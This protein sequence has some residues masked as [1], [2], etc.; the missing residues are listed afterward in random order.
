[1]GLFNSQVLA[2]GDKNP[3]AKSKLEKYIKRDMK[4]PKEIQQRHLEVKSPVLGLVSDQTLGSKDFA[5]SWW[6]ISEP[7]EM[8]SEPHAHDF[9]QFLIFVGGDIKNMTDLGGEVELTLGVNK[10]KLEKFVF[11][12]ATTVYVPAGLLHCPL[13]FK[14][15]NDPKKPIL[16]HDFFFSRDYKRKEK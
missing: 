14:K 6:P 13:N 7:F 5:L 10:K 3:M 1:V 8:I 4:V 2:K 9:D 12:K 15:V 16:F 11:T